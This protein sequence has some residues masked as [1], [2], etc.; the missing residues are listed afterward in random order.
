MKKAEENAAK[1]KAQQEEAAKKKAEEDAAKKKEAEEDAAKK[2]TLRK[3][4]RSLY[5][6]RFEDPDFEGP[7]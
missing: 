7:Q 4:W 3:M 2:E 1:K 5:E 6:K